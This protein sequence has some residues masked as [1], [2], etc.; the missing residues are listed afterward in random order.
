MKTIFRRPCF[1][2]S[3]YAVVTAL[4]V[5]S[6]L[7]EVFNNDEI[8]K[9]KTSRQLPTRIQAG[10]TPADITIAGGPSQVVGTGDF[11]GD[12]A[13]DFLVN[14]QRAVGDLGATV[15]LKFGIIFGKRNQGQP[16]TINLASDEP[17]LSLTVGN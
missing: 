3:M 4:L 7:L 8:T 17:D 2:K 5:F 13:D 15:F 6:N 12:G 1:L 9:A 16:T 11:N 14:Y 10:E